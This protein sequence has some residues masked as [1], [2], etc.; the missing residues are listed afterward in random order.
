MASAD[1]ALYA[2]KRSS[3]S[4]RRASR[5]EIVPAAASAPAA[6]Y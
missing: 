5:S 6:S 2:A 1:A 4:H 3:A